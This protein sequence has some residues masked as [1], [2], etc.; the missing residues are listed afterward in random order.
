MTNDKISVVLSMNLF[1]VRVI[2]TVDSGL[3]VLVCIDIKIVVGMV[4][5]L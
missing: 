1:A 4:P 2:L 5:E 3:L